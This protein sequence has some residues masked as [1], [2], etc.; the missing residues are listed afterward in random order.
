[1][2]TE[3]DIVID[4]DDEFLH[5]CRPPRVKRW[6]HNALWSCPD[7]GR[8]WVCRKS[9]DVWRWERT[10]LVVTAGTYAAKPTPVRTISS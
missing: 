8:V 6:H 7:D 5:F 3:A 10:N 2:S 4:G 1:M 9:F